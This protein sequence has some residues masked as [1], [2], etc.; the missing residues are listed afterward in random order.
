MNET[1]DYLRKLV[2]ELGLEMK[3]SAVCTQV[4]RIR[5]GNFLL[6]HALLYK[7]WTAQNI[8]DNIKLCRA[9]AEGTRHEHRAQIKSRHNE[10]SPTMLQPLPDF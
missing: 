1:T 8:V 2:H 4:R 3:A 6:Q 9:L 10:S 7:H 5:Y